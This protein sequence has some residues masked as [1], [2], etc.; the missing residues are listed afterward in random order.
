MR[1]YILSL[2]TLAT[3]S[4]VSTIEIGESQLFLDNPL[5]SNGNPF[6]ESTHELFVNP[7]FSN[8]VLAS[9]TL[10]DQ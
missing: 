2:V 8:E 9:K 5:K 1:R 7:W 6:D 4:V 3:I 10:T